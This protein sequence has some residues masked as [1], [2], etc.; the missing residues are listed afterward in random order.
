MFAIRSPFET[1]SCYFDSAGTE[2]PLT[3]RQILANAIAGPMPVSLRFEACRCGAYLER[4]IL[5]SIFRLTAD[6]PNREFPTEPSFGGR[7]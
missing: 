6:D 4:C 2:L 7:A 5:S 1:Y 3:T